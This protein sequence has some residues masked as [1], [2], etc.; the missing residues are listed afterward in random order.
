MRAQP[1]QRRM[2]YGRQGCNEHPK[3]YQNQMRINHKGRWDDT[4]RYK[5]HP[6]AC[7]YRGTWYSVHL[8]ISSAISTNNM[9]FRLFIF[10]TVV[11][12]KSNA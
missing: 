4:Y 11:N 10:V 6:Y 7:D 2:K 8:Y 9:R 3:C 1:D 12:A 5:L